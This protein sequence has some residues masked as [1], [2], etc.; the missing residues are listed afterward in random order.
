[1]TMFRRLQARLDQVQGEANSTLNVAKD[2]LAD[3][4]DGFGVTVT[5]DEGAAQILLGIILHGKAGKLPLKIVV[6]PQVDA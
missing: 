5:I 4:K 2:L 6:D 1:M 3:L